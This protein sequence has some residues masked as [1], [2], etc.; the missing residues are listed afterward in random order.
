MAESEQ[1]E[2]FSTE[3]S[4][5]ADFAPADMPAHAKEV[6][7]ERRR[8]RRTL[9]VVAAVVV[10]LLAVYLG[11]V[12]WYSSHFV[13]NAKVGGHDV[14]NMDVDTA[15]S[16]LDASEDTYALTVTG[17]GLDFTIEGEDN[18]L[19][20]DAA[21]VIDTAMQGN[22]PWGWPLYLIHASELDLA[23]AM[24]VAY[25]EEKLA[26]CVNAQVD[27]VNKD[28]T[29]PTSATIEYSKD[30]KAFE[31]VAEKAGTKLDAAAV[32]AKVEEAAQEMQPLAEIGE[33]ELVQP[34]VV[35]G[36]ERLTKAQE[37]A[38]ELI[39][40]DIQL[41]LNDLDWLEV[42]SATIAKWVAVDEDLN[43]SLDES[44][45]RDWTGS[46][47]GKINTVGKK[48][49]FKTPGGTKVKVKG[50]S[51]GWRIDY[52]PFVTALIEAVN[53][54]KKGELEVPYTQAA[55]AIPDDDGV[56]FGTKYIDVDLKNQH[57]TF[58][59]GKKVIWESDF[60]SGSPD[61][62]HD[63][64]T[65]VYCVNKKES[66]STL[67]GE[68]VPVETTTGNGKKAKTT[69]TY[70]PEYETE[71]TYWM[72]FVGN[73]VGF[74]DATWQPGFGGTM[75]KE[76]YGSHGCINLPLDAAKSLYKLVETGTPVIVHK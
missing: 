23:D 27:A 4:S 37:A 11:G 64:P 30:T 58:Y 71:V 48:R 6:A 38:N 68:M 33:D 41:T 22:D 51:Y 19:S 40:A 61:G 1:N 63:T 20:F 32:L 5:A 36:D 75:Y 54:H 42:D 13:A 73:D 72:P 53:E 24:Q 69:I 10:A 52:E 21:T 74:H 62:E 18:G 35:S 70:E 28:A 45:L 29:D 59:D 14:S 43:V 9:I 8:L 56:D 12:A 25:D 26:D 50:G 39:D 67:K 46:K 47:T 2:Q 57:A 60:I 31:V 17:E 34:D 76:G 15:V 55:A 49:T 65:G 66:P 44:A 3:S 16:Y 7:H